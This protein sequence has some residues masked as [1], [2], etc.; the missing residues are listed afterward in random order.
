M[1][2]SD[3]SRDKEITNHKMPGL[4]EVNSSGNL[5][6][7]SLDRCRFMINF[8]LHFVTLDQRKVFTATSF[9]LSLFSS[10][11]LLTVNLLP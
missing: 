8:F 1:C 10:T 9:E 6:P 5:G 2:H 7:Y 11:S 4:E 3:F